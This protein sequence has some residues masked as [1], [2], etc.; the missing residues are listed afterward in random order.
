MTDNR[1]TGI[2][3]GDLAG[4]L[5]QESYPVTKTEL[6]DRFGDRRLE[7]ADGSTSLR[8]VLGGTG[9]D[10]YRDVEEVRQ[11]IMNMIGDDAVGRKSYTDRGASETGNREPDSL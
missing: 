7:Q 1:E 5:E 9:D 11:S 4:D 8:D 6:L 2:E 10:E 3:F